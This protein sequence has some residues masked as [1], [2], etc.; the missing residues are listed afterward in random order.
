MFPFSSTSFL[1][2][3]WAETSSP[4]VARTETERSHGE[5]EQTINWLSHFEESAGDPTEVAEVVMKAMSDENPKPRYMIVPNRE[6][7]DHQPEYY[8][9]KNIFV[10]LETLGPPCLQPSAL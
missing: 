2:W 3:P 4:T 1:T 8:T 6:Q 10:S 7:A 9:Q 5:M